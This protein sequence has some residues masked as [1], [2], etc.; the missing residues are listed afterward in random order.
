MTGEDLNALYGAMIMP[1][2]RV[3]VPEAWMPAI[4]EAM[5][6]F[7]GLPPDVRAF[8]IVTDIATDAEGD[9]AF[10]CALLPDHLGPEG[11]QLIREITDRALEATSAIGVRS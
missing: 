9:L 8:C 4:H 6:A 5:Q 10:H 3:A 2:A 11:L 1:S 7:V